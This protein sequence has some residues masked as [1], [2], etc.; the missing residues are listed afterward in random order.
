MT[1]VRRAVLTLP[2][3]PLGPDSP[4]PALR[5]H[6]GTH[7]VDEQTLAELPRDMARGIGH[8][9]LRSLLPAPVRD[10]YGRERTP[11]DLDAIVIENDRIRATVLPGLGGRVHSLFHKAGG[12]ELLYRNPVIQPA[13]F[14]LNGAWFSGGIEWNIGATG[15]TTLSCSPLHAAVVRAPDGGRMLR[16]WEWERLRDLPFQVDLWLPDGSDFLHVGVRIRNPH[17]RPAP[18]Y[19][20]SNTAVPEDRRVIAPADAAWHHGYERSLRRLPFPVPESGGG[21]DR[22][23]PLN[24]DHAADWFYDLPDGQRRWIAALDADGTGLVQTSTDPLR[25][26]KLFLW[27]RERGGRRWQEWLTEPG[28]PGYAEIQ[29]GLARTQL[30]HLELPGGGEFSWLEAYGPLAA[31][32]AAAL[33]D[34]W[35]AAREAVEGGLAEALPRAAV[36]TAYTA[37]REQ[38]ADS[39]P[40]TVLAVGSGWG[41]LE[42]L[43]G[44]FELPGTPFPESTL[45]PEQEPWRALLDTGVLPAPEKGAAPGAPLVSSPWR[46]MLETAPADPSTE[47]H[48]GI[49]QW[50]AGDR[51]QAVRS[52]ERGLREAAVRWP[53]LRCL[54]VA[55]REDGHPARAAERFAEA[56][57]DHTDHTDQADRAAEDE[58]V[59]A[60]LGREAVTALLAAGRAGRA[61]ET[62]KRLPEE[63]RGRGAFRLLEARLLLAEGRKDEA[64]AVFGAGFEVAD[65]RE[66]V[67]ILGEV[68]AEI[69]DEPLPYAYEFRMRP[70]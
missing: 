48:L 1:T 69:T 39:G 50:H 45:G 64:R 22:S 35:G 19:W 55:D 28:T 7:A 8:A 23:Y 34:D 47:Y 6:H 11:T 16:L 57:T 53:L 63:A 51:A 26:R 67:E 14:A 31:D 10:G 30:E 56:F 21:T 65:L 24:G 29:A 40:E 41:A 49:A 20:W 66:G 2:A 42:V 60:A 13:A 62:W 9:P 4:L 33:G 70:S 27:G 54:A 5:T 43:R 12:R 3:A 18:V 61:R 38:A 17:E 58:V 68:W 25:G 59:S 46:D 32:P 44:H 52:W 36:D 37:W 15:H